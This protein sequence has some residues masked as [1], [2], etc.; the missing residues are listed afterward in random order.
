MIFR[1]LLTSQ[2]WCST[3]V[4]YFIRASG[5]MLAAAASVGFAQTK[6]AEYEHYSD[7]VTREELNTFVQSYIDTLKTSWKCAVQIDKITVYTESVAVALDVLG[8]D[9]TDAIVELQKR[10]AASGLKFRIVR[11]Y[12][13]TQRSAKRRTN[14]TSRKLLGQDLLNSVNPDV[15]P[16]AESIETQE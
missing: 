14:V 13:F 2:K 10:S 16:N 6:Q 9:C 7:V 12:T 11:D 8:R 3:D 4:T 1:H 5:V 15:P